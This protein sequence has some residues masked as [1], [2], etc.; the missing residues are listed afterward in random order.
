MGPPRALVMAL[1]NNLPA[2]HE[3]RPDRGIGACVTETTACFSQSRAHKNLVIT[4]F[5]HRLRYLA[6]G[7]QANRLVVMKDWATFK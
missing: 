6:S 1:R 5:S 7:M 3:D 4:T 2:Y